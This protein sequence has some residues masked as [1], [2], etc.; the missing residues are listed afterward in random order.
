[1][2]VLLAIGEC[3][4]ASISTSS[5]DIISSSALSFF[6]LLF[7]D[8]YFT[9]YVYSQS[10]CKPSISLLQ[11]QAFSFRSS[12]VCNVSYATRTVNNI[13]MYSFKRK[14]A[15]YALSIAVF[16]AEND[17]CKIECHLVLWNYR[18]VRLMQ[19]PSVIRPDLWVA[20]LLITLASA[21]GSFTSA[22]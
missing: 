10:I 22:R 8:I 9:V 13:A 17:L 7:S 6:I 4:K 14:H 2:V 1:M 11:A 20:N 16:Y 12:F 5:R 19:N 15:L 3:I 21:A 18:L